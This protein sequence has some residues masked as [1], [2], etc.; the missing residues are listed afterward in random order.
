M[1]EADDIR[2]IL[3]KLAEVRQRQVPGFGFE[4]HRYA[5]N[6]PATEATVAAFEAEHGVALPTGYRRFV[7]EAGD[8]GA[9]P[10]YG[11]LPLVAWNGHRI[12]EGVDRFLAWPSPLRPG[13]A[14]GNDWLD[15]A[16]LTYDGALQ[17]TLNLVH[18]GCTYHSLLVV[19]GPYRGRVVNADLDMTGPPWFTRDADFLAWYERW[20]DEL[21]WGYDT[22]WFGRGLPG[23][24]ADVVAALRVPDQPA[25]VVVDALVTLRRMPTLGRETLDVAHGLAGHPA[26]EV[27]RLAVSLLAKHGH[28]AAYAAALGALRDPAA[29]VRKAAVGVVAAAGGD[30]WAAAVR[31]ALADA[32]R[33]VAFR[34]LCV[35][36]DAAAL[37]PTDVRPLLASPVAEVRRNGLWVAAPPQL[38]IPGVDDDTRLRRATAARALADGIAEDAARLL[39]DADAS[40]R[41]EAVRVVRHGPAAEAARL[42]TARLGGE[43]DLQVLCIVIRALGELADPA[44]VRPLLRLTAHADAFVRLDAARAL[45]RIGDPAA[46]DTL[47]RLADDHAKAVRRGA[48]GSVVAA[49][50]NTVAEVARA[51][52][53]DIRSRTASGGR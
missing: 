34:A 7:T 52:L 30:G 37:T 2:R 49:N 9:G 50:R 36:K 53:D 24:E 11:L 39:A 40:V 25:D 35:L 29:D 16:G 17:G 51:A 15:A 20:L 13:L 5:L 19:T 41:R 28:P 43:P 27:R 26:A 18:Q 46:T 33:G 45:G 3:A 38:V 10:Y 8:G 31:P 1:E 47:S 21:L 42:L 14:G 4:K 23:R 44:A 32:D 48:N 6:P 12:D 22:T